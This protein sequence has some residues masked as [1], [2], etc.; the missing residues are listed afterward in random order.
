VSLLSTAVVVAAEVAP[1]E[2]KVTPGAIGFFV[3]LAFAVATF[4]LWRS[5]NRHL[6]R[7]PPSFEGDAAPGPGDTGPAQ[8]PSSATGAAP[9]TDNGTD[10][11]TGTGTG[12]GTRPGS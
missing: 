12:T 7:V 1:D 2:D 8:D 6:K 5:M 4:F 9:D 10:N 11:G 3:F